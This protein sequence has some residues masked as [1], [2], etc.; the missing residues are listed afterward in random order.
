MPS[1]PT[2]GECQG[3]TPVRGVEHFCAWLGDQQPDIVHF[4]TFGTGLG[5]YEIKAARAAGARVIATTHS[6]SLGFLCQRGTMM[7][8][9]EHLCD[10]I[11]EPAKCSACELQHRGLNKILA[12]SV[13]L[14]P[15]TISG[16][17]AKLPGS[18][19]TA[20]GMSDLITFNQHQQSEM[21]QL[22]DKFVVLTAWALDTLIANGAPA[23]KLWLNRLG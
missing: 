19:G 23:E 16:L 1:N 4:H 20:L 15:P 12:R 7:R 5:L 22:V 9:G 6:A 2:R 14:L 13:S 3:R 8:W 18:L 21:Y 10:G 17:A 11:C